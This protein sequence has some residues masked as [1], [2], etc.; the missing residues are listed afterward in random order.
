MSRS[1]IFGHDQPG[2]VVVPEGRL[3][4]GH[5][6]GILVVDCHYPFFPGNVSNAATVDF[7]VIYELVSGVAWEKLATGDPVALEAIIP[8]G[9]N[10]VR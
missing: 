6:V 5:A 9:R 1:Y 2:E 7:P 3:S 8:G 4:A 10:L